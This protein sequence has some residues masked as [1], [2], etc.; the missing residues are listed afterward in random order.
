MI[1]LLENVH[2][3]FPRLQTRK[4]SPQKAIAWEIEFSVESSQ[5]PKADVFHQ[6]ILLLVDL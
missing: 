2:R 5:G 6:Q 1:E 4:R 3:V